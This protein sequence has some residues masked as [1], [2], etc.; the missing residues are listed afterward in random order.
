MKKHTEMID[1]SK[2]KKMERES[3][4]LLHDYKSCLEW[5]NL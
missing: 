4:G 5:K 3:Q 2:R 1:L